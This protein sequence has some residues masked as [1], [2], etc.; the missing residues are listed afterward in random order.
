MADVGPV[1][2]RVV[3]HAPRARAV[4]GLR[5]HHGAGHAVDHV[6]LV[7]AV[8][9]HKRQA[10][11]V[12]CGHGGRLRDDIVGNQRYGGNRR[13]RVGRQ[14]AQVTAGEVRHVHP[15]AGGVD[16]HTP[17]RIAHSGLTQH[18]ISEAVQHQQTV[19]VAAGDIHA[20][21]DR[22]D[23]QAVGR[24]HAWHWHSS[25]GRQAG[26]RLHG[27]RALLG[28][29]IGLLSLNATQNAWPGAAQGQACNQQ[30]EHQ[31][32]E[33]VGE[34]GARGSTATRTGRGKRG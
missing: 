14:D 29:W 16:G 5:R 31:A 7:G 32:I 22:I 24:L 17:R 6:E 8:V 10:E 18:A 12:R 26:Q 25:I 11:A 2:L 30:T 21:G 19:V 20:M 33:A 1:Q 9:R 4:G 15:L 13:Q 27:R 23:R 28:G 34:K 3:G